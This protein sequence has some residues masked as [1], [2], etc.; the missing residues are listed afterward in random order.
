MADYIL[1]GKDDKLLSAVDSKEISVPKRRYNSFATKAESNESL[2]GLLEDPM[3]AQDIENTAKP[4]GPENK[5][6]YKVCRQEIRR[7]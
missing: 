5:S 7:T 6:P 3:V 1:F 4:V 2:D